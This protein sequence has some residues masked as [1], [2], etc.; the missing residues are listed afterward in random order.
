MDRTTAAGTITN[1]NFMNRSGFSHY[2][3]QPLKISQDSILGQ[4][5]NK[6][7]LGEVDKSTLKKFSGVEDPS[8]LQFLASISVGDC[9]T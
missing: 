4:T 9:N 8:S 7:E 6:Y 5:L 1:N 2:P 3:G